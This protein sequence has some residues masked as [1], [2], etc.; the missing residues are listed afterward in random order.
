MREAFSMV[1]FRNPCGWLPA[2]NQL[3]FPLLP[4]ILRHYLPAILLG[5][6]GAALASWLCP[7]EYQ[8]VA[9]HMAGFPDSHTRAHFLRPT[10]LSI[11][12]FIPALGAFY[13]CSAKALDRYLIRQF[14]VAFGICFAAIYAIWLIIDLADKVGDFR[15]SENGMALMLTYYGIQLPFVFVELS[16][17]GLLLGLLY[18]LGKLSASQEIVSMIQTGRGVMR[19]IAPLAV[20]G[21]LSSL[22]CLGFNYQWAPWASGYKRVILEE[23][24]NGTSSMAQNVVFYEKEQ[25]RLWFIGSFPFEYNKGKPL[26]NVIVRS[27]DQEGD[28]V[29][30]MHAASASWNRDTKNWIFEDVEICHLNK[31]LT[32]DGPFLPAWE[33]PT[34]P[35][36][37]ENWPETPWQLIKPGLKAEHLGI[38]GLYSWLLINRDESWV[39]KRRFLTQWHYRWAQPG[40]C[41]AIV[42][43]AAPL[44]IVF[45][46]R[47]AAGGVAVSIFLCAGMMFSS[48]VFL[49]LGESGYLK[50][51]WAAWGTNILATVIA[52]FLIQRR[53]MGMP[54]Y[55]TLKKLLPF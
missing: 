37:A 16:P 53:L 35:V 13:Y 50:P 54:I 8:A 49:S 2:R 41:L 3:R 18:C 33:A 29:S 48:V 15:E 11:L 25:R 40:I 9:D 30:A 55:H 38:P 20:I 31:R 1:F 5:I 19:I 51:I 23:A 45:T 34:E 24:K 17:F 12:C 28:P 43:L 22:F 10:V 46:R 21:V 27:F 47:G 14:L 4:A 42:L 26:S 52:L 39:N 6:L 7:I 32:P 36:V 44:G